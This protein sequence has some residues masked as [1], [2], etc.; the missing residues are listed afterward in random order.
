V[1]DPSRTRIHHR[2]EVPYTPGVPA[3]QLGSRLHQDTEDLHRQMAAYSTADP[4]PYQP[5][6]IPNFSVFERAMILL[7]CLLVMAFVIVNFVIYWRVYVALQELA[8][9][10]SQIPGLGN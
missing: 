9:E 5:E 7:T 10:L 4:Y 1:N 6:V 3:P 8:K 2:G